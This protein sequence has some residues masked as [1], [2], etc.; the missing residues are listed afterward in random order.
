MLPI[1]KNDEIAPNIFEMV[2]E[3]PRLAQKAQPGH[4]VIVMTDETG[5]R[6][7]LT[8]ADFDRAAGTITLVIM[9]IGT[10]TRKLVRFKA[11]EKL[12]AMIGPLGHASELDNFGTVIMVAGGVGTAPVYPI[13]RALHEKGNHVI[14]IQGTR[15]KE[16]LFWT[17]K[18]AAVSDE[19]L[20]TTD[21][22]SAGKKALVT[23]PLREILET[24]T[25]E[26]GCVYMIGPAIMMKFCAK[27]I[28]P[29]G[30]K[31]VASLNSVMIDGTG[32]CG[33]CRVKIGNDTKFTCVD[34]P[35]FD[36]SLIDW[37][38]L[39]ARQKMYCEEE[40]CSLNR[41]LSDTANRNHHL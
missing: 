33:G 30:V 36:A 37:D 9:A 19:H 28:V 39:L 27:T 12:P 29:F 24:R 13:A 20:I 25:N 5:E 21:D 11:G 38:I 1:L 14:S 3:H 40:K 31:G 2:I 23:E 10:S 4:F 18:L 22:G 26:I 15:N 8:V 16:L 32:M 35:E 34:G 41:Y 7:P 6:I 17:E